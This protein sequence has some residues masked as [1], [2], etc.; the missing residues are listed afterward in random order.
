MKYRNILDEIRVRKE[1]DSKL[2]DED[3][4]ELFFN[5]ISITSNVYGISFN[6]E[7]KEISQQDFQRIQIIQSLNYLEKKE[8][9]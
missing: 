5:S 4:W 8:I 6:G 3:V 7:V 2:D 1:K 9:L